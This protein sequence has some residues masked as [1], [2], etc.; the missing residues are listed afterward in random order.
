MA[1]SYGTAARIAVRE[2][3]SSRGKFAFV[4]LSVAIGV[5]AL[6]GVRGF[7][8]AFRAELLLRARSILAADIAAK[9]TTPLTPE[10][11]A[12]ME[13][14]RASGDDE[15]QVTEL[16]SMASAAGSLDPLLV[17]V[18]A[19]EPG[20]WPFYGSVVLVPKMPLT[21]ALTASSVAVGDDLLLRLHLRVGDSIKLGGQVFR[22]AAAV[23]DEPDRL[24]GAFAAGPR[25]LISQA[26]L[27]GTGLVA[28]GS[29]ASRR[30]LFRLP[31]VAVGSSLKDKD[32]AAL[33]T[34][35][36]TLLPEAQVS[37][38]RE[39][40]ASLTKALDG[41]T[42][43]LSLMSL[44]ALVLGAV[45]VAMAMRAHLQQRLDSIAI[46]KSLGAGSAQVMKIY[47]MQTVMLG[48]GGGV[49]GVVMGL[50]VQAAFPLFLAKLLHLTPA[51]RLDAHA[52]GLGLMAGLLTTLLFTL[53]PLLDIRGV[54]PILI[55]RRNVEVSDDP[56]VARV[57]KKL[58]GSLVQLGASVVIL[59]GLIW[60][61]YRVSDSLRVGTTFAVGLAVALLVLLGMA[62][63][64]LWL[65]RVFLRGT[66]L[67]LPSVLRHGLANLYRPGNPSAALLAALGLGVMQIAAV[68]MVQRSIVNEMQVAV[69]D[70]VPNLF[71]IDMTSDEVGGIKALLA[72]QSSVQ[73]T[74]EIVPVV[75]AR[76]T[77]VNGAKPDRLKEPREGGRG[78]R[79]DRDGRS[80][81]GVNLTWAPTAEVPPPGDKVVDGAWWT[82]EQAAASVKTPLVAVERGRAERLKAKVG[83][84]IT[85]AIQDQDITATVAATFEADSQH[86]FSRAEFVMP[87]PMLAGAPVV[88]YGGVH[89]KPGATGELRR[90]LYDKYPTV[91]VIDVAATLEVIRQVLL[92]ITYVIQ[93]LA[94]FSI[95]AGIV[96]LASA[97]AGTKYRRVREVVVLKTLGATRARIAAIFSVE[98]AVL[99]LIAGAVGLVFANVLA[100][101]LLHSLHFEYGFQP[102]LT[103]SAWL[104]TGALTV[105]AGWIASYRVLGQKPLE[106]LREE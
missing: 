50:G 8:T 11:Q 82:A 20:K 97:I 47:V 87:Q 104:T 48:L 43:L 38:Y 69:A 62:A 64:T 31:A 40:N 59:V 33:K 14:L 73:G 22:I 76:L 86:S 70:K 51:V 68:Y 23:E 18:K 27:A 10:Q 32:V 42:G 46:M 56:F 101:V 103:I 89:C 5:A 19:V 28:P 83:D 26:A 34:Q 44:V 75:G 81:Y 13:T 88:W 16:L 84:T 17:S 29:H 25:V 100:R 58:R 1:L 21:Q 41:A 24:S 54:R 37:D 77:L 94:A 66:R 74:P 39:A 2:L 99:G 63:L 52:V 79:G 55:L 45:G 71:L 61:A 93:F 67:H 85:F 57:G 80:A 53:P 72:G 4:V 105:A 90:A 30:Y 102:G 9:T 3:R 92:Q 49:L 65:L 6:T 106:V 91:T 98:F 96:I 36:E 95:F 35:L 15:T 60:L 7:S 12:G 78:D